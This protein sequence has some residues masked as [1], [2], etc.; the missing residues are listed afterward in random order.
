MKIGEKIENSIRKDVMKKKIRQKQKSAKYLSKYLSK[1]YKILQ[2]T[3]KDRKKNNCNAMK[4]NI[5]GMKIC[6][7]V[8]KKKSER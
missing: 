2:N 1:Y 7:K 4:N 5:K 3:T 8:R 6:E